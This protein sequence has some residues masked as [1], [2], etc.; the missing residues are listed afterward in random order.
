MPQKIQLEIAIDADGN[1]RIETHGLQGEECLAE[2]AALEKQLGEVAAREKT[3]EYYAK[4]A[5]SRARTAQR[6]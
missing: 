4:A 1:V 2:T 6:R 5:S 3:S